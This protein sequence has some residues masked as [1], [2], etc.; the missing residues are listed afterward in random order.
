MSKI[1]IEIDGTDISLK[2]D[3]KTVD[4]LK[5]IYIDG[6]VDPSYGYCD[7]C[8]TVMPDKK[9]GESFRKMIQYKYD[10]AKATFSSEKVVDL[11]RP[12]KEDY[13]GM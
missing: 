8:Y 2:I 3:G 11:K 4:N 5:Y 13:K 12:T 7:F 9:D 6:A 10:P 1:N